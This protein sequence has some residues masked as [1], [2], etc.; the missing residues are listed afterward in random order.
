MPSDSLSE[1]DPPTTL[2]TRVLDLIDF[3]FGGLFFFS[4]FFGDSA[5]LLLLRGILLQR[6]V[7]SSEALIFFLV[8]GLSSSLEEPLNL[9]LDFSFIA[10]GITCG[11]TLIGLSLSESLEP[12]CDRS[13]LP[14]SLVVIVG[15][16]S[17][18]FFFMGLPT[19]LVLLRGLLVFFA[20][21][22]AVR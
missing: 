12:P 15:F 11:D 20:F 5:N 3:A 18:A 22:S 16:E 14:S 1:S 7:S 17:G 13:S 4:G 21:S 2:V 19:P 9:D 6:A 8:G 10:G